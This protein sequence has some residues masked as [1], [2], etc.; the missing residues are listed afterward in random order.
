MLGQLAGCFE[1]GV[2]PGR[3]EHE[4]LDLVGGV[5][6]VASDFVAEVGGA[7]HGEHGYVELAA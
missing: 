5:F 3:G 6:H 4:A 2:V 1:R 7:S